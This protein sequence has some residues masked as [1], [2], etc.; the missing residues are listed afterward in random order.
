MLRSDRKQ[1]NSV[2]QLSFNLKKK[3]LGIM[4][5]IAVFGGGFT[6][7]PGRRKF[8]SEMITAWSVGWWWKLKGMRLG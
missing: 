5:L 6:G 4:Y 2:K 8:Q 1:Q 7:R 3:H